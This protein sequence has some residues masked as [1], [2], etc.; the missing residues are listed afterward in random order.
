MIELF[1]RLLKYMPRRR[2]RQLWIISALVLAA[3]LAEGLSVG[4]VIPFLGVLMAPENVFKLP[5][6]QPILT[7]LSLS[8]PEQLIAPLT[9]LFAFATLCAGATRLLAL[10]ATTRW[11]YATGSDLS[12]DIYRRTLHQPYAVH[13]ARNS[14]EI[15]AGITHKVGGVIGGMLHLVTILTSFAV[16]TSI[17]VALL[18]INPIIASLSIVGFGSIYAVV[19]VASRGA[20]KRNSESISSQT[21]VVVKAL[22]EGLGGIRDI[23]L[24]GTQAVY[25]ERYRISDAILRNAQG[26]NTIFS[27]SPR[28]IIE[29]VSMLLVAFLAYIMSIRDGGFGGAIPTL[30]AIALGAQRM[31]PAMQTAYS[32]WVNLKG[33]SDSF[34]DAIRLLEQKLPDY[35]DGIPV[36]PFTFSEVL[37]LRDISFRYHNEGPWVLRNV[38]LQLHAGSRIGFVGMTGSGKSTFLDI[39]MGLLAPEE[40]SIAVDGHI[41]T[42]SNLRRWQACIAHVPQ[43]IFLV[44]GTIEENIAFGVKSGMI[45]KQLVRL[46][47]KQA[48]LHETIEGMKLGYETVVGERGVRLSGGQRQRIGIARALY[49]RCKVIIFDEATSA[50]DMQTERELIEAIEQLNVDSTVLMVAH[51]ISTLRG[52]STIVEFE[53]SRIKR[54]GSYLDFTRSSEGQQVV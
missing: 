47:A 6:L 11:A 48:Q 39:V 54:I 24:D 8:A 40:G 53:N 34:R 49:K 3:S 33:D 23:L 43:S 32:S 29:T 9:F 35:A 44:D 38:S 7:K 45:N 46:A 12:I 41:L 36:L 21:V 2:V 42:S 16:L 1:F 50:L 17:L 52:C 18:L 37:E 10:W 26:S 30:G 19:I 28:F 31:L 25:C 27:S 22:Q 20:L 13:L 4:A 5:F 14:S 15:V 51:R